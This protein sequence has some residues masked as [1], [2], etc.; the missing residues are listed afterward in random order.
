MNGSLESGEFE[1]RWLT[2]SPDS[3]RRQST[4]FADPGKGFFMYQFLQAVAS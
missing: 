4:D 2:V 3:F 1:L